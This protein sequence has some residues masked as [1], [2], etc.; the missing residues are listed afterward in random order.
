MPQDVERLAVPGGQ[1]LQVDGRLMTVLER[2]I[3]VND[4]ALGARGDGGLGEALTDPLGDLARGDPVV[5]LLDRPIRQLDP[6]HCRH[7]PAD[8]CLPAGM[9]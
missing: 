6:N 5:I 9:A 1:D 8:S 3:Q 4:P 7:L 2:P